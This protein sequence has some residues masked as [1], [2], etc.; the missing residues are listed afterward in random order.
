MSPDDP[1]CQE[2]ELNGTEEVAPFI[3]FHRVLNIAGQYRRLG[4]LVQAVMRV[5]V[6]ALP[7]LS[8]PAKPHNP[9]RPRRA[10]L[11]LSIRPAFGTG[12]SK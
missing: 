5:E 7:E 10:I 6:C 1:V 11:S 9:S 12:R 2:T 3:L 8:R 4:A